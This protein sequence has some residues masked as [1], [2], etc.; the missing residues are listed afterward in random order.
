MTKHILGVGDRRHAVKIRK[1]DLYET[2]PEATQALLRAEKLP[3]RIWEPACGP[4]AIARVLR[5]AG[6]RVLSSDLVDYSS[7]D[8]DKARWDFLMET[9]LPAGIEAIVTNPPF[10]NA[11]AFVS[12]AIEL[13]PRVAMLLRLSFLES[14]GR[15]EILEGGYLARVHVFRNRLQMMHRDGW[16][17]PKSNNSMSFAWFVWDR[18]HK[19]P[20]E[21]HR[22]S[23]DRKG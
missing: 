23:W 15:T 14:Q 7:K 13:C 4:G 12:K 16:E 22:I 2:A 19:G 11:N 18:A 3:P 1:D 21:L 8:Q 17:G 5:S 9:T 20:T 10:K 6:H